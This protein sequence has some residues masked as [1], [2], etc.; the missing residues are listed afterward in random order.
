VPTP[1]ADDI[2]KLICE[3][4]ELVKLRLAEV[5][6]SPR[7]PRGEAF[8]KLTHELVRHEAA[9]EV[10]VYPALRQLPRG[11]AVADS[12]IEEQS[13]AE[14]LLAHMEDMDTAGESF[15][16]ALGE[17]TQAVLSHAEHEEKDVV[18]LLA[19]SETSA[20]LLELGERYQTA[21]N[22]APTHPHPNPPDAP[23]VNKVV[24]PVAALYDRIRDEISS[25]V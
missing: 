2:I 20:R 3:D 22:S 5:P 17:L 14:Q 16:S 1:P 12:C 25:V 10:V 4:H 24:G 18:S 21:K 23:P 8:W 13:E 9:E 15:L 7:D 19:E 6:K 11:G